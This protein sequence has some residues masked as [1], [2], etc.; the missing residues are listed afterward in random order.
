MP[1]LSRSAAN[2][3]QASAADAP[4]VRLRDVINMIIG[5]MIAV[6][7]WFNGDDAYSHGAI[8]LRFVAACICGLSLWI[9]VHQR[10]VKAEFMNTALGIAL[11][12]APLWRG[13]IDPYRVDMAG[14]GAIVA[15]FSASCAIRILRERRVERRLARRDQVKYKPSLN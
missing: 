9:I 3:A 1:D 11:V 14:A 8:R 15:V 7:P 12:T 5:V 4:E 13:G 10:D 6:A 2:P